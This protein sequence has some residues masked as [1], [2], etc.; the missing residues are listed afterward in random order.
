M[1][2]LYLLHASEIF[3]LQRPPSEVEG[4]INKYIANQISFCFA[5]N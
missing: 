3:I 2:R 4:L 1:Q 5:G